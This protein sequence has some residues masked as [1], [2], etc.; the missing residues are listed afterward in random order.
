MVVVCMTHLSANTLLRVPTLM[1]RH[2]QVLLQGSLLK[3]ILLRQVILI[4]SSPRRPPLAPLAACSPL[5][6]LRLPPVHLTLL[7]PTLFPLILRAPPSMLHLSLLHHPIQSVYR[8]IPTLIRLRLPRP[9]RTSRQ[10]RRL[11]LSTTLPRAH[12][13]LFVLIPLPRRHQLHPNRTLALRLRLTQHTVVLRTPRPALLLTLLRQ[14][15]APAPQ[16]MLHRAL[17]LILLHRALTPSLP[18]LLRTLIP[19]KVLASRP[20]PPRHQTQQFQPPAALQLLLLMSTPLSSTSTS[21]SR[22]HTQ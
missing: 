21:S 4:L 18:S 22:T 10:V 17:H 2:C 1:R 6:P 16:R 5:L 8:R 14:S 13:R 9:H 20:G 3:I 15:Q 12:Q 7:Q 19:A 11:Q